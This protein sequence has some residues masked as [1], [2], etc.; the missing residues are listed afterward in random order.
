MDCFL[1]QEKPDPKVTLLR[2]GCYVC[3]PCYCSLKSNRIYN[4]PSCDAVLWRGCRKN[5]TKKN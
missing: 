5:K 3:P 1:C 4:C 2:C